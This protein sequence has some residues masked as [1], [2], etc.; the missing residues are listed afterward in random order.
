MNAAA[1]RSYSTKGLRRCLPACT[2]WYGA[3]IAHRVHRYGWHAR[4]PA[5][6]TVYLGRSLEEAV[7]AA[8]ALGVDFGRA[9]V[10]C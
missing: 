7:P 4:T 10:G 8:Q 3:A 5:G 6:Y 9:P 2:V 1:T